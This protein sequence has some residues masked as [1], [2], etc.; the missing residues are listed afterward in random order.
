[1]EKKLAFSLAATAVTLV[2]GMNVEVNATSSVVTASK[3]PSILAITPDPSGRDYPQTMFT[4]QQSPNVA[5][6]YE[7]GADNNGTAAVTTANVTRGN[8]TYGAYIGTAGSGTARAC[9]NSGTT[10]VTA[11]PDAKSATTCTF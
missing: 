2:V 3:N 5:M 6:N 10:Q 4:F 11:P 7:L 1:M 8:R 9:Q